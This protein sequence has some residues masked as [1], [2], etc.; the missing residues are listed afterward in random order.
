V[1]DLVYLVYDLVYPGHSIQAPRRVPPFHRDWSLLT[2]EDVTWPCEDICP[3]AR[4]VL[5]HVW[6]YVCI[7]YMKCFA[8]SIQCINLSHVQCLI[9]PVI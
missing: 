7:H 3:R 8:L 4:L 5:A 2:C 9:R 6:S 1:S